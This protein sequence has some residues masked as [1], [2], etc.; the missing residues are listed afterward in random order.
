M[1]TLDYVECQRVLYRFVRALDEGKFDEVAA[2]MAD[3]GVW[4]RQGEVLKGRA[5]VVAALNK[6]GPAVLTRHM[7]TNIVIESTGPDSALSRCTTLVYRSEASTAPP[8]KMDLPRSVADYEDRFVRRN[9]RWEIFERR[10]SRIFAK[11]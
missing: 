3:D 7:V 5:A 4:H 9:G 10:S 11:E 2:T 1:D 6:R 8:V